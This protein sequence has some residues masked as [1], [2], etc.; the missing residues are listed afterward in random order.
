MKKSIKLISLFIISLVMIFVGKETVFAADDAPSSFTAVSYKMASNPVGL[1]TNNI[2]VKK[3]SDGK[4]IYCY[5]VNDVVPN[6]IKYTKKELI[7]DPIINYIAA[8]GL[9]QDDNDSEFFS[10]QAT[11]WIYL[12]EKGKMQDTEYGYINKIKK[13]VSNNPSNPVYARILGIIDGTKKYSEITMASVEIGTNNVNFT[14][15]DGYYVSNLIKVNK[16]SAN[17]EVSL[18]DAP[19][20]TTAEKTSTGFIVKVPEASVSKGSTISFT[21]TVS[22]NKYNTY[23]YV[24]S[25]SKY[26]DMLLASRE[27][28]TDS[29]KLSITRAKDP[30]VT[31]DLKPEPKPELDPTV[32]KISKVDITNGNELPGATLVIKN[33]KGEVVEKW[34]STNEPKMIDTLPVGKYTLEET[35][36]P[37][38]YVLS[39]EVINFE[40]KKDGKIK[41]VTMENKPEEIKETVVRII[42]F[43]VNDEN[44]RLAGATLVVKNSEGKEEGR[45]KTDESGVWTIKGL[46]EGKYTVEEIEAPTGYKKL[47]NPI[48]FE[49]VNNGEVTEV[50][51]PNTPVATEIIEVPDTG[52]FASNITYIIGGLVIIIGSVLIYRNAKKEQ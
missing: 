39:T 10:T 20:G 37:E 36:A 7:T 5:D 40:V 21:A 22:A 51:V 44:K 27:L 9:T 13:A 16:A 43:D 18:K 50:L 46:A 11:L 24:A 28:T 14:L 31:P 4:Y 30:V 34:V 12:L 26:Q 49:V 48:T 38:G 25:D 32:I 45:Y 8:Q 17:Y 35:I 42:K 29:I 2:S 23:R 41:T 52:S 1:E 15:E 47:E 33:S 19:N 6:N 3:T